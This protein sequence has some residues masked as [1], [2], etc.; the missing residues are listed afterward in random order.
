MANGSRGAIVRIAAAAAEIVD[1]DRSV[2]AALRVATG[3][4]RKR[5]M[6]IVRRMAAAADRSARTVRAALD[7]NVRIVADRIVAD[8][9]RNGAAA[10]AAAPVAGNR[11]HAVAAEIVRA[12]RVRMAKSAASARARG[13]INPVAVRV[14]AGAAAVVVA[15]VQVRARRVRGKSA[16]RVP[17][18]PIAR[19][20]TKAAMSKGVRRA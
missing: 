12:R 16:S 20:V 11:I 7:R 1:R 3:R 5:L 2:K 13:R 8:R 9:G 4:I 10:A 19:N 18:D 6:A 14:E 17:V 15:A